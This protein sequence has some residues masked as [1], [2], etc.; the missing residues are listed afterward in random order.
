MFYE[1]GKVIKKKGVWRVP[2]VALEIK[3]VT[4]CLLFLQYLHDQ[5]QQT[6]SI[7]KILSKKSGT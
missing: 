7:L 1:V 2:L 3:H 4:H 6:P 5:F